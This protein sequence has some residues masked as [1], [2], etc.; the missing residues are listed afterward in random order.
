M[1]GFIIKYIY[2][3]SR[4]SITVEIIKPISEASRH[5]YCKCGREMGKVYSVSIKTSDG[6]K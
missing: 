2:H 6:S 3:C 5:E 1:E 4:C